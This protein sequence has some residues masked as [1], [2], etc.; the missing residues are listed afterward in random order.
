MLGRKVNFAEPKGSEWGPGFKTML[1]RTVADPGT[2][3]RAPHHTGLGGRDLHG[4]L[5]TLQGQQGLLRLDAVPGFHQDL[6]DLDPGEVPDVG[7]Q[8][9]F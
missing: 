7:D 8:D 5:V 6:D 1:T 9:V 4:G 3:A 2:F